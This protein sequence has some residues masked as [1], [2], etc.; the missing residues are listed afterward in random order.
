MSDKATELWDAL[1]D[2]K[3]DYMTRDEDVCSIPERLAAQSHGELLAALEHRECCECCL[4][5][6]HVCSELV[7]IQDKALARECERLEEALK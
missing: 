5:Q 2:A 3:G 1:V 7:R 6:L 4:E